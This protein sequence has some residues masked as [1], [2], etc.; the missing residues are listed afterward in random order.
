MTFT[1]TAADGWRTGDR[2]PGGE[3]TQDIPAEEPRAF[4]V[5]QAC[6]ML[7]ISRSHL[8]ALAAKGELRLV[9]LGSRTLVPAV[10]INRLLGEGA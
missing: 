7:S 6:K 5:N 4:R 2:S 8:Y 10:E 9:R 3:A 1:A